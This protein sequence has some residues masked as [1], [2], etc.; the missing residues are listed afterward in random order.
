MVGKK[1]YDNLCLKKLRYHYVKSVVWN[2]GNNKISA[3]EHSCIVIKFTYLQT[4]ILFYLPPQNFCPKLRTLSNDLIYSHYKNVMRYMSLHFDFAKMRTI[5]YYSTKM[6]TWRVK[7]S[8][9]L[10]PLQR[11]SNAESAPTP[12]CHPVFQWRSRQTFSFN[13]GPRLRNKT[14][15]HWI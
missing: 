3:V 1:W 4:S 8:Y 14:I 5:L 12:W 11:V 2:T 6:F 13:R 7:T 15:Y 10:F 9:F